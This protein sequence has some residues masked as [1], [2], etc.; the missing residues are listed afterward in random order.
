MA[1]LEKRAGMSVLRC[2][3]ES[4]VRTEEDK[5]CSRKRRCFVVEALSQSQW[6]CVGRTEVTESVHT[7]GMMVV[8]A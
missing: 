5:E 6:G 4:T 8:L 2:S 7:G 1:Q 3:E